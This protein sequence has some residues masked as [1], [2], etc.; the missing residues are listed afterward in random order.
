MQYNVAIIGQSGVGKSSLINYL[1]GDNIRETGSGEPVTERGFHPTSFQL[2]NLPITIFDSWGLEPDKAEDW[3]FDLKNTLH[4]RGIDRPADQWIHSFFFCI[5]APKLRVQDFELEIIKELIKERCPVT[6]LF[7]KADNVPEEKIEAIRQEIRKKF[8]D[9]VNM[10]NVCSVEKTTRRGRIEPFGKN[11]I[12]REISAHFHKALLKRVPLRCVY[13]LE[14]YIDAWEANER[15]FLNENVGL[16]NRKKP[17]EDMQSHTK[18][19]I[20]QLNN[21][22]IESI[23]YEEIELTIRM[24]DT[25]HQ[26]LNLDQNLPMVN[27]TKINVNLALRD[28]DKTESIAIIVANLLLPIGIFF[29]KSINYDDLCKELNRNTTIIKDKLKEL[30]KVIR[31]IMSDL[32]EVA[33]T[34]DNH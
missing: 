19:L 9:I 29:T 17:F 26:K 28:Y 20:R 11:E 1:F 15:T 12:K 8:G 25:L 27:H 31:K 10:V 22:L 21:G 33:S 7:T 16:F 4:E 3:M 5:A 6:V 23:V 18:K 32:L 14:A 30:T 24:F 13:Q 2:E 34:T